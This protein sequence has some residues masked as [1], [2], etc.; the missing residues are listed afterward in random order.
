[1][2]LEFVSFTLKVTIQNGE[3]YLMTN[4]D[5]IQELLNKAHDFNLAHFHGSENSQIKVKNGDDKNDV[6]G[7]V[8]AE[9]KLDPLNSVNTFHI[10]L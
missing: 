1:M 7:R 5:S 8:T 9:I 4:P 6:R 3:T 2:E 10:P